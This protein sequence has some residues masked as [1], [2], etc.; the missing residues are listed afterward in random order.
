MKLACKYCETPVVIRKSYIYFSCMCDDEIRI[1]KFNPTVDIKSFNHN[2]LYLL[3]T[4][5]NKLLCQTG[6]EN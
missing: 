5:G 4:E 6:K 1:I 3:P 2:N